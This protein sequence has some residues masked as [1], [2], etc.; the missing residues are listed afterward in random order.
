MHQLHESLASTWEIL[1]QG[2]RHLLERAGQALTCFTPKQRGSVEG[3]GELVARQGARWALLA[4]ELREEADRVVV[5]LEAPG[6]T[7]EAFEV[8]VV[9][10][11]LVIRGE[12]QAE[13]DE[14]AGHFHLMECAYGRFERAIPIPVAVSPSHTR[15]RYHHGVLTVT[16][17]KQVSPIDSQ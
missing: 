13:R 14:S 3:P 12:K 11:Y 17:P 7:V 1:A 6:M 8:G 4:A 15:A 10:D 9:G 2:W 5:R 16:L